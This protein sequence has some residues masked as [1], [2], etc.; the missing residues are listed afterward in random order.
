FGKVGG[1][2]RDTMFQQLFW[3]VRQKGRMRGGQIRLARDGARRG[4]GA[5]F[6]RAA[7]GGYQ[8]FGEAWRIAG[9]LETHAC[10]VN[11]LARPSARA[12]ERQSCCLA[13]ER[14]GGLADGAANHLER[15]ARR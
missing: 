15:V 14:P 11:A 5:E 12:A 10:G 7:R 6:Y 9:K 1:P 8:P 3:P 4:L 2:L 13:G